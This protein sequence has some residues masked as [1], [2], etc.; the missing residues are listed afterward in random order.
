M[1]EQLRHLL[2]VVPGI[3]G[4]VLEDDR[5]RVVWGLNPGLLRTGVAPALLATEG[6]PRLWPTGLMPDIR[7][8][9]PMLAPGYGGLV[10]RIRGAFPQA[11][12]DTAVP[13]R[14]RDLAADVVL[15]PYDFRLGVVDAAERL[16]AEVDARLGHL[17]PRERHGRVIVL[18]HSMGGLVA[19]H[20]AGPLGGHTDCAYL[21]TLGT[22]Y[23]GAPKALKY[24]CEGVPFGG[25]G[26]ASMLRGWRSIYDLLP[27]YRMVLPE[28]AEPLWDQALY[29][30]QTIGSDGSSGSEEAAKEAF[31]AHREAQEVWD[32]LTVEGKG[33][34]VVPLFSFGHATH[35]HAI[36]KDGRPRVSKK[37]AAWLPNPGWGGDG[38]VPSISAIPVESDIDKSPGP[39]SHR[40]LRIAAA[41]E[42]VALLRLRSGDS[43]TSVTGGEEAAWLGLDLEPVVAAY[44]PFRVGVRLWQARADERTRV[45]VRVRPVALPT[46]PNPS[47]S[48]RTLTCEGSPDADGWWWVELPGLPAGTHRLRV[49]ALG[50]PEVGELSQEEFIG[51]VETEVG[52]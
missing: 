34:Q 19:R 35:S 7:V 40:H 29:P 2:V 10:T 5:G 24:L 3:L 14:D 26:F 46:T 22:P 23:R 13:G 4:S 15:F 51:V 12:V 9:P 44:R 16:K 27:R 1:S 33:C 31:R 30:H 28:G 48:P 52:A 20:W 6:H 41:K 8:L 49:D 21:I 17:P 43:V 39:L 36:V 45:S 50:V 37:A 18:A 25:E 38:T 32:R 42:A 47:P 11:R